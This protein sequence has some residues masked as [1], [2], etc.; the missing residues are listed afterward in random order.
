MTTA[1]LAGTSPAQKI[2][3]LA[4][5]ELRLVVRNRTLAVSAL[6]VPLALGVF[7]AFSF[8]RRPEVWPMVVSLQAAVTLGMGLYVTGTQ[9][10]VARR[11]SRVLQRMRTSGISDGGLLLATL[12]PALVV[13]LVQLVLF[14][15]I[16]VVIGGPLPSNPVALVA[17]VVAGIV[18]MV[19][20]ALGT[21]VLTPTPERAQI[22][23]LPMVFLMLGAAIAMAVVPA[24]GWLQAL[25]V[26][27]G[28]GVGMLVRLAFGGEVGLGAGLGTL[29][30]TL[31]LLVWG[32]VFGRIAARRFRW[33]PRNG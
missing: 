21:S 15:V 30:A 2:T 8:G 10:I 29:V 14:A 9:T 18:L 22:T 20:A 31:S 25:L 7:W 26:V 28:A 16:D 13:A 23:T 12:T 4:G 6:L 19:G 33:D 5:T 3:A 27:P 32:G 24:T 1:T 11:H 17:A